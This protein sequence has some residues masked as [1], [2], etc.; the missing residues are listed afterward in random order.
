MAKPIH[1]MI[2]VLDEERSLAFYESV[3]GMS[4][5]ER[6]EFDTFTL[7]YLRGEGSEFELELTVNKGR[8]EPYDLG[9]G[10]GHIAFVVDELEPFHAAARAAGAAPRDIVEFSPGGSLLAKFFFVADP[11]GYQIEVIEKGGRF[12]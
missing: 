6:L 10:Y 3:F 5:A 4:V 7:I 11:D 2:R 9:G 12:R 1:S 8:Q